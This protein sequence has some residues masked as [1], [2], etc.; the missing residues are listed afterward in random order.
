MSVPIYVDAYSGY[1]ANERPERFTLDDDTHT[2]ATIEDRWYEPGA[3]YFKVKTT[4]AKTYLL[5]YEQEHDAW[6]LQSGFDGDALLARP[7]TE[8]I[9]V[10]PAQVRQA[11]SQIE[12]CESCHPDDAEIPFDWVLGQVTGREGKV[13]FL[14]T[15]TAHCPS[16][17]QVVS[18]KTSVEP[19]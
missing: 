15:E 5:R 3:E 19:R 6:T 9:P 4:D 8:I 11:E 2:I 13:D 18:E 14:M 17:R 1:R 7:G 12:V 16:C 10:D